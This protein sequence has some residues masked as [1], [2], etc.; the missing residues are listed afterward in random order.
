MNY[1]S[2]YYNK[3]VPPQCPTSW[4][5]KPRPQP[6]LKTY[7]YCTNFR[8]AS[9]PSNT[10]APGPPTYRHWP[11]CWRPRMPP[12]DS[13]TSSGTK[14]RGGLSGRGPI[15]DHWWLGSGTGKFK[16]R[17]RPGTGTGPPV[18]TF[19][20]R[21]RIWSIGRTSTCSRMSATT[22]FRLWR[23][24]RRGSGILGRCCR[25]GSWAGT[26]RSRI[27]RYTSRRR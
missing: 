26:R 8:K 10:P 2:V 17:G 11:G 9:S 14:T 21:R 6:W 4:P 7:Y 3:P 20:S 25:R 23:P 5:P 24:M 15:L 18:A 13:R 19:T 1:N 22:S 16:S 27:P 12:T